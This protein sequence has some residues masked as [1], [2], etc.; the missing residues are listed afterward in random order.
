MQ[1]IPSHGNLAKIIKRIFIAKEGFILVEFDFSAHEVRCW[2]NASGDRKLAESFRTGLKLRQKLRTL[3][4]LTL[5]SIRKIKKQIE[6]KGDIHSNNYQFFFGRSPRNKD[7]RQGIKAVVF[8]VIYGKGPGS[9]AIDINPP[10]KKMKIDALNKQIK[11][12]DNQ[13]AELEDVK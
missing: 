12:I 13:I 2:A 10:T 9:L 1:Q 3:K 4:K 6:D 8:G 11:E 7:E 5:K